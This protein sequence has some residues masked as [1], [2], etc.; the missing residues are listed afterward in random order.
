[1]DHVIP[2]IYD[3]TQRN[4]VTSVGG[5]VV[6]DPIEIGQMQSITFKVKFVK[7]GV[8][9]ALTTPTFS[10]GIKALNAVGAGYLLQ[11][12]TPTVSGF[13]ATTV[14]EFELL[15]DSSQLRA[16][17]ASYLPSYLG[18][19]YALE[20]R[21]SFNNIATL[22]ALSTKIYP[23]YTIVGTSPTTAVGTWNIAAGQTFT[24]N[25]TFAMPLDDGTAG[26][27]LRTD[28]A[29]VGT[30]IENKIGTV[31][32]VAVT[33]ANGVSGTVANPTTSAAITIALG[34]ITPTTGAFSNATNAT[35]S[36]DAPLK[37][38]GGLAVAQNAYI[39][40]DLTV[41]GFS[42]LEGASFDEDAVMNS[43][44]IL[45]G[46]KIRADDLVISDSA[47]NAPIASFNSTGDVDQY[48]TFENVTSNACH[49]Y[50]S[51]LSAPVGCGLH[52]RA[53]AGGF[54]NIEDSTDNTKCIKFDPSSQSN[55]TV[56]TI[57]TA[58]ITSN[59]TYTIPDSGT[60]GFLMDNSPYISASF[61][62]WTGQTTV[63][64]GASATAT[65][66]FGA[67]T[68]TSLKTRVFSPLEYTSSVVAALVVGGGVYIAKKIQCASSITC[69]GT[70]NSFGA[71]TVTGNLTCGNLI[72]TPEVVAMVGSSSGTISMS[73]LISSVSHSS[74]GTS[75]VTLGNGTVGQIKIIT[76]TSIS[77]GSI[78]IGA[79]TKTGFTTIT[80]S[81]SYNSVTLV[82]IGS[83]SGWMIV[84]NYGCTIA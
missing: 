38:A 50:V 34:A 47:Y 39:G 57:K 32:N 22:P 5:S 46:N 66:G 15:I 13:G 72:S 31:T 1:M 8:Q 20:I 69:T 84:S 62:D 19:S 79:T 61:L 44:L 74:A 40:T 55:S 51:T 11:F 29:G 7:D 82:Y 56:A 41:S 35:S 28:G 10:G 81:V 67:T 9:Y 78:A 43:D 25:K 3:V 2:L 70:A 4:W 30:W 63:T 45:Y 12:S 68:S 37:T 83:S 65:I 17:I 23:D 14:Y 21:E 58:G 80:M 77:A 48:I 18:F 73:Y 75:I 59:A 52:L 54:V 6:Q 27:I 33:T 60:G 36:T 71:T 24:V 76:A 64:I 42:Y 26:F 49:I 53:L 16:F